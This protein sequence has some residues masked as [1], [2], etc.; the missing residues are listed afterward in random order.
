MNDCIDSTVQPFI[1]AEQ[2]R[3][4]SVTCCSRLFEERRDDSV[5]TRRFAMYKRLDNSQILTATQNMLGNL[6]N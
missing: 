6:I 2:V 3:T 1:V 4:R 5:E